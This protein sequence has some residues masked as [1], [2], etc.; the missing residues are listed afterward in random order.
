MKSKLLSK[1]LVAFLM[2]AI[3]VPSTFFIA[4]QRAHAYLG[5]GDTNLFGD[6]S[7]YSTALSTAYSVA[8]QTLIA[9]DTYASKAALYALYI[10]TYVLQP[11][12]FI[13]SGNLLKSMTSGVVAFVNGAANGTGAPQFVQN[14]QGHLQTVGDTQAL[15]FFAQFGRNS[16]SP[17][18]A[19]INSSLRTNYL[20]NTSLAGFWAFNQCT[21]S[22]S[23]PNVNRFLAGDWSQGG[24]SAWFALTT[25][26]QN[27]PYA[28][29]Q[30]TQSELASMVASAQAARSAVISF[31]QGFLSWCGAS[32]STI[33]STVSLGTGVNPGDPCTNSDGS[34][35]VIKTPGSV[36]SASLNK[37]LG[38]TAEKL[39]QMGQLT[40][41]VNSILGNVA[42]VAQTAQFASQ[43]L[44]GPNSQGLFG[45]GQTSGLNSRGFLGITTSDVYQN[46]AT[47]P[48]SGADKSELIAKY[49]SAWNTIST[50]ANTASA[51]ITDLADY[52]TAQIELARSSN[53]SGAFV[54][55][56]NSNTAQINSS[57]AAITNQVAPV[58]AQAAAASTIIAAAK[59]M[60]Q[61]IQ[62]ELDSST[63][64]TGSAYTADMQTL[65]NMSPTSDDLGNAQQ[66]AQSFTVGNPSGSGSSA[67][68]SP[69]GSLNVTAG[70]LVDK[71]NL[72][73]ANATALK[74][75]C[76]LQAFI[77][78]HSGS[79]GGD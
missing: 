30:R 40:S 20:Q 8:K 37:A 53:N 63:D 13:M 22:R 2:V 64:T 39:I 49:Q 65:Q 3:I 56:I 14:L 19:A 50:A 55:F 7:N 4:P 15:A 12:A 5:V 44:G 78:A 6:I 10:N 69:A 70:S 61:K 62:N 67:T 77:D 66:N 23:S 31:G 71:M 54:D 25:Q 43:I 21:L 18:A 26:D 72:L 11:L 47:L 24:A 79:S 48:M 17:F 58:L 75:S 57:Q 36:I 9:I 76:N 68:A 73:S 29:Y 46:A 16:N 28:L 41:E 59:A 34:P 45:A 74:A 33:G 32:D 60:V 42:T 52:C 51:N 38:Y 1:T 27:N 35:G